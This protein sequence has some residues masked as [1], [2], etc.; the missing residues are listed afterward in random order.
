VKIPKKQWDWY[1][2]RRYL[3]FSISINCYFNSPKGAKLIAS[4]IDFKEDYFTI[5]KDN[6]YIPTKVKEII[7]DYQLKGLKEQGPEFM[8]KITK[9][10]E[11]EGET[12]IKTIKTITSKN[13]TTLD[14]KQLADALTTA[15]KQYR[16]FTPF[17]IFPRSMEDFFDKETKRIIEKRKVTPEELAKYHENFTAPIKLTQSQKEGLT[18]L[19]IASEIEQKN[20]SVE[21][22]EIRKKIQEHLNQ[23]SWIQVRWFVGEPLSEK[24]ITQRLQGAL[25]EKPTNKLKELREIPQK[26]EEETKRICDE[27]KC[28]EE[29]Q[30][31]IKLAKEYVYLRT[32]RADVLNEANFCL[33]PLIREI[34]KKLNT[35]YEDLLYLSWNEIIDGISAGK[36]SSTINIPERKKSWALYRDEETIIVLQGEQEVEEFGKEQGFVQEDLSKLTEVKGNKAYGGKVKGTAKIV[37]SP[38]ELGKVEKG[39]ILVAVMTFPSYIVAMEKASAFVT[40]EGGIL[41]HAAII[42]REMKK[43]CIIGT[44]MAT[45]VFKDGEKIEVDAEKGVVR[46]L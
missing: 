4:T 40:D 45:R 31:I 35:Q 20:L 19:E 10:C 27:L 15:V 28:T 2:E 30:E 24:D 44:K 3:P 18:F 41:S 7:G 32:Y 6:C 12:L 1:V 16:I 14:N 36:I 29:E 37:M 5:W 23:F 17:L 8:W 39:D 25:K 43:P 33:T 22:P 38:T 21:T 42:S 11:Q 46:K 9:K 13:L 26:I 34:A